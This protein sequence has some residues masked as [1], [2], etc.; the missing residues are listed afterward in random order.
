MHAHACSKCYICLYVDIDRYI[1]IAHQSYM[2][3]SF[4]NTPYFQVTGEGHT[5]KDVCQKY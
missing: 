5:W 2:P 3:K 1:L 4:L